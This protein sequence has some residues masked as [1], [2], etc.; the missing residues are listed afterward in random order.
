MP[1]SAETPFARHGAVMLVGEGN[2]S[3]ARALVRRGLAPQALVATSFDAREAVCAK[4]A[5]AEE[6][7][8]E[9]QA[10]LRSR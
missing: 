5:D 4:Y 6:I 8:A 2:F 3:F 10:Q 7:M 1:V 9:L